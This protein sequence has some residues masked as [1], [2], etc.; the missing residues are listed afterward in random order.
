MTTVQAD[1]VALQQTAQGITGMIG[2]LTDLG[3]KE[4]AASG[5]GFSLLTMAPLEAGSAE[6]QE[7]FENYCSRWS[8]GVRSL[9][10]AGNEIAVALG[11]AAGR[12]HM[13]ESKTS[14]MFKTMWTHTMGN[15]HLT[16]DEIEQRSW[17]ET[18]ADNPV[19]QVLNA[20]YSRESF[21]DAAVT[22]DRNWRVVQEVGPQAAA[23]LSV[24][25][26]PLLVPVVSDATGETPAWDTDATE[27]AAEIMAPE[28]P[29]G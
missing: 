14:D 9:V 2:V 8:W 11:L 28:T 10:Q 29:Q 1:P 17:E 27:R 23:N 5:R 15:P 20:D 7:S 26:N 25:G 3:I 19:N 21:E 4:T 6:V 12:Y 18:L 13:M 22:V 24:L 16:R